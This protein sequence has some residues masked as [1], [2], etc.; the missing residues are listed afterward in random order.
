MTGVSTGFAATAV[1]E[2]TAGSVPDGVRM[3]ITTATTIAAI[4]TGTQSARG[5]RRPLRAYDTVCGFSV[6]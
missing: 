3:A 2:C 6:P 1:A 4:A 5:V